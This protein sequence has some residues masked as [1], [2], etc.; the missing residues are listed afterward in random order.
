MILDEKFQGRK[1]SCESYCRIQ[2][3]PAVRL[4]RIDVAQQLIKMRLAFCLV[5]GESKNHEVGGTP[6][7]L[8]NFV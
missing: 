3:G 6:L 4:N 2:I 7:P 5:Y 8:R 1:N